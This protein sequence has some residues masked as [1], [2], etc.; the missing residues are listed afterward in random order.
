MWRHTTHR[1]VLQTADSGLWSKSTEEKVPANNGGV[2]LTPCMHTGLKP[3]TLV[4]RP[5][6]GSQPTEPLL[7]WQNRVKFD[8]LT[9]NLSADME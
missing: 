4:Q 2:A 6:H 9:L 3:R 8:I 7:S 1:I 5:Y